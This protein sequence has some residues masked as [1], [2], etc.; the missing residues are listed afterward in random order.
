M[1]LSTNFILLTA[2]L[3]GVVLCGLFALIFPT[4]WT[5]P[6][7]AF[8]AVQNA[9]C[10]AVECR[11][12]TPCKMIGKQRDPVA[13]QVAQYASFFF[14][15]MFLGSVAEAAN[16]E[17]SIRSLP[18]FGIGSMMVWFGMLVRSVAIYQ[19]GPSFIS[20]IDLC[21]RSKI[22][23][24]GIY[25]SLKHP[26]EVGFLMLAIGMAIQLQGIWSLWIGGILLSSISCWRIRR[27][28]LFL[29]ES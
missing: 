20:D 19:L 3:H 25:R 27:E 5:D 4:F 23:R 24:T 28:D 22:R 29:F 7:L 21:D 6:R 17:P 11:L 12:Q 15:L 8:S 9:A 2:T 13:I 16:A 14:L 10:A 18:A 26:G 1:K